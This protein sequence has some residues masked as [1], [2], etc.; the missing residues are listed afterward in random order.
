MD[1]WIWIRSQD[2]GL[3][4]LKIILPP[5]ED[6]SLWGKIEGEC[7]LLGQY[8]SKERAIE[9]LDEIQ[10]NI[11]CFCILKHTDNSFNEK[12]EYFSCHVYEMPKE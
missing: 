11:E 4:E 3:Y 7:V 8:H 2:N 6:G 1:L 12:N 9:V 10:N 5:F